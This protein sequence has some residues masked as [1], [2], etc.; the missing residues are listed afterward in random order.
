MVKLAAG[1]TVK[2]CETGCAAAYVALP[3]CV[4]CMVQVPGLLRVATVPETVHTPV[5]SEVKLT[6]KPEVAEATRLSVVPCAW[7]PMGLKV[8]VWVASTVKLCETGCAAA[9]VALPD[10]DACMVQVPGLVRVATVPETVHTPVVSEAKL[11]G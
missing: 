11:T 3:D 9:Y 4:A 5:V 1:N 2:L 10:C 7:F 8:I 6:G